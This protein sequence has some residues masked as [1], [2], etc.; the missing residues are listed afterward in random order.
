MASITHKKVSTIPDEAD[1]DLVLPSDW[2]DEHSLS[3]PA[4]DPALIDAGF[5]TSASAGSAYQP[6]GDYVGSASLA[7]TLAAYLTSASASALY[8]TSASAGLSAYLTSASA[9]AK[10]V[11]S[12]SLVSALALKASATLSLSQ[13]LDV[14][15]SATVSDG[16]FLR[17]ADG[18]W[19]NES[20]AP[21]G[22]ESTES[23]SAMILTALGP[24]ITS[25]SASAAFVTS[26]SLTTLLATYLTSASASAAYLTSASAAL[27]T[28]LTSASA[29]ALYVTS[30][31]LA[32][33]LGGY[34]TSASA[35]ALYLT[36]ASAALSTYVTSS[37]LATALGPYLT[38][39]SAALSTYITSSSLAT[40]LATYVT[41]ASA[42][43]SH[44]VKLFSGAIGATTFPGITASF[45]GTFGELV[46]SVGYLTTAAATPIPRLQLS[47]DN[48]SS[49]F[50]IVNAIRP[51]P[52]SVSFA[53]ASQYMVEFKVVM[54]GAR[55]FGCGSA[56]CTNA[57][58]GVAT[59]T[60]FT[61]FENTSTATTGTVVNQVI[62]CHTVAG[63]TKTISAGYITV[64]GVP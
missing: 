35:S 2:N 64:Y 21:G 19:R 16:Q 36:S 43:S 20:V 6:A 33:T 41:S 58:L 56:F 18:K 53:A 3:I 49:N 48:G 28:Y 52:G 45:A 30:A 17:Y 5:L 44:P 31:S 10:Y 26:A 29:S 55:V 61:W 46:V 1:T 60:D 15:L 42:R 12:D 47:T 4:A 50:L 7:T 13:L 37:S 24:Y 38:S 59:D 27:S 11:S 54:T 32:T 57:A 63:T 40:A 51:T 25:A 8:L 22:G 14:S 34:L 62:F 9:S 39:A 23:I